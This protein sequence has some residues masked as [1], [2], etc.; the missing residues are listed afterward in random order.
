MHTDLFIL[1]WD[2]EVWNSNSI[3]VICNTDYCYYDYIWSFVNAP[4]TL[5]IYHKVGLCPQC[6]WKK[7]K[8]GKVQIIVN[9]EQRCVLVDEDFIEN[10]RFEND[11]KWEGKDPR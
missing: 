7:K 8:M 11:F 3:S 6:L 4:C 5:W 1:I 10:V 2:F 9:T